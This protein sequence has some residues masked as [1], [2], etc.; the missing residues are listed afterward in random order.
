MSEKFNH[1]EI[2]SKWQ[3]HWK[4]NN[5]FQ[6]QKDS[7]KEK[8]YILEMFPYTSGR[9]HIGHVR[10]YTMGDVLARMYRAQNY[11]V[12]YPMGWD[13][14][15]L[16]A[17]NAAIKNNLHPREFTY[18]AMEAMTESMG[19][20]GLSYDWG[21]EIATCDPKYIK[22]Q[23]QLFIEFFKNGH[24]YRDQRYV[25]WDPVEQSVLANEQVVDGKG[26]RSGADVIKKKIPQWFFDIRRYADELIDDLDGL[27]GWSS[28]IKNIQRTW[29]GRSKGAEVLFKLAEDENVVFD[30]FT[31]R[32]DTLAGA[33]FLAL[34]PEHEL[35]DELDFD[36]ELRQKINDFR[37][38]I[39]Q[40]P[41]AERSKA[42]LEKEGINTGYHGI[43][44]YTGET[45]PI[46]IA[47]YIMM[48]YG[49]GAIMAVPAHDQRDF[50][51]A[52]KYD[53]PIKIVVKGEDIEADT[54]L[55]EAYTEDGVLVNSGA[56]DGLN[57][58]EAQSKIIKILGE[59]E[60]GKWTK[61]YRLQNW[62]VSRQRAWGNPIP[63]IHCEDCGAV[64]VPDA[65]LPI[66]LPKERIPD[67]SGSPLSRVPEFINCKCPKCGK[68]ARRDEDTMDTFVDSSWYFMRFLS[69]DGEKPVDT[70]LA[71]RMLPVD[72]YIGGVEHATMHLI[73]AR[74]FTKLLRDL[75]YIDFS[76]P[77]NSLYNHGMVN[78]EHGEKQSKS[79]GNV[80]EPLDVIKNL[81]A[82]AARVYLM[83]KTSYNAP[84]DWNEADLNGARNY[85]DKVWRM[86][87]KYA[88][89]LA[90]YDG[91]DVS[92]GACTTPAE[93][94]LRLRIHH[95]IM[96]VSDDTSKFQFN[97]A[98]AECMILT[99][100]LN[101]YDLANNNPDLASAAYRV[102][103]RLLS[104]YA[105]HMTEEIWS[106][107]GN[108][109]CLAETDWPTYDEAAMVKDTI[110]L[111][112]Q[113]NGKFVLPVSVPNNAEEGVAKE[114][115]MAA[116]SVQKR[117][118]DKEIRKIIYV[119]NKII[120]IIAA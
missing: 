59:Q 54:D 108:E 119:P 71:N 10:N 109:T 23:Q 58:K 76:E 48:D 11:D 17:E 104:I 36:D 4:S 8:K 21:Q 110:N 65:D 38:E 114:A 25:N 5:V 14:F 74:Y 31:T 84:I 107:L 82:D 49:S 73:Y 115:A 102:L 86:R 51:F 32:P 40:Q 80:V 2:E 89:A 113:V 94:E 93:K 41:V 70:E 46:Y 101:D 43:N 88:E 33:T 16:P 72:T 62:S 92:A 13:A 66:D 63:I 29:I 90:G 60:T 61:Q 99:N 7:S 79:K 53:L 39:L 97:T 95:A 6:W 19:K 30:V 117:I 22:A 26:W 120:N 96:K 106:A 98:I 9:L 103:V 1:L 55:V 12:L 18:G 111:A 57:V 34:A 47:N 67:G 78:D 52:K 35:I 24:V 68:D 112:V 116:D 118:A 69:P 64:P 100:A 3:D 81:G 44:P 87:E 75:G 91:L 27:D 28:S 56:I 15:G 83:F 42:D 50:E 37:E 77:F 85:L 45:V 105:P 20:V